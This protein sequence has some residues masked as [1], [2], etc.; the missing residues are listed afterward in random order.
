M[1]KLFKTIKNLPFTTDVKQASVD[2]GIMFSYNGGDF[3]LTQHTNHILLRQVGEDTLNVIDIFNT[4]NP[5]NI[6]LHDLL[7]A[8]D[9]WGE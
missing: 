2:N 7:W 3:L 1:D 4:N 6:D 9:V 8:C 5:Y